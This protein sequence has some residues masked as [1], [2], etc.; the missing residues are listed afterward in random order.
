[1][2]TGVAEGTAHEFFSI[3]NGDNQSQ[4]ACFTIPAGK[5]GL[6][7]SLDAGIANRTQGAARVTFAARPFGGVFNVKEVLGVR[8]DG[9]SP[10]RNYPI[11]FGPF[12][13]KTDLLVKALSN[14]A[15]LGI[16]ARFDVLMI[17]TD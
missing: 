9:G 5:I 2:I 11:P 14:A 15:N 16:F 13:E 17:P 12:T 8:S 10:P 7:L 6:I 4:I 3:Q 1:M